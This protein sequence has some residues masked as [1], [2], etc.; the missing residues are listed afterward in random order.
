MF[1]CGSWLKK[2]SRPLLVEDSR[3]SW[4]RVGGCS[5]QLSPPGDT[6]GTPRCPLAGDRKLNHATFPVNMNGHEST[7]NVLL[8]KKD[9]VL[10]VEAHISASFLLTAE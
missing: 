7:W 10:R 4:R 6:L 8:G 2:V 5:Q 3:C 9:Q 1:Y